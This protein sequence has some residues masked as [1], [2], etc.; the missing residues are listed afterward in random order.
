MA[1]GSQ[2]TL[3]WFNK[4]RSFLILNSHNVPV[5]KLHDEAKDARVNSGKNWSREDCIGSIRWIISFRSTY[6][7]VNAGALC[8][9]AY[10]WKR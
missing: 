10:A 3:S 1:P 4:L 8:G 2:C 5:A 6:P 9:I 7:P